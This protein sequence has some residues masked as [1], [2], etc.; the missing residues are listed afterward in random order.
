LQER[1]ISVDGCLTVGKSDKE[2]LILGQLCNIL[3]LNSAG[4]SAVELCTDVAENRFE[5]VLE[6]SDKLLTHLSLCSMYARSAV[7]SSDLVTPNRQEC[8]NNRSRAENNI[9]GTR[10]TIYTI[11]Y[12][13]KLCASFV[14]DTIV[15]EQQTVFVS[16]PTY[17][18][19]DKRRQ[20][21]VAAYQC[22]NEI[23]LVSG[24]FTVNMCMTS[25]GP[26]LLSII[27]SLHETFVRDWI[28]A[29]YS[30]DI[31]LAMFLIAFNIEPK[32]FNPVHNVKPCIQITGVVV[33]L[34]EYFKIFNEPSNA[35]L[36]RLL[37]DSK[38]IQVSH[39]I[40]EN[41]ANR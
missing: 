14:F 37:S 15:S 16:C 10:H 21:E 22:C 9:R 3:S 31:Y 7:E 1:K 28:Q 32:F 6:N 40:D 13:H 11:V 25:T 23:G 26:K 12:R 8:C 29:I 36:L 27:P 39:G 17:L 38:V 24:L 20:L 19:W 18:P 4:L 33:P 41:D 35:K 30:V 5:T 34:M 2:L